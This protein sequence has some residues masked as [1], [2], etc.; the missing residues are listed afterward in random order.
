MTT[1]LIDPRRPTGRR[2][3]FRA[4]DTAAGARV[5]AAM[6]AALGPG[7]VHPLAPPEQEEVPPCT[8]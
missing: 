7:R 5:V 6:R 4:D 3:E 8:S 1:Y 2:H